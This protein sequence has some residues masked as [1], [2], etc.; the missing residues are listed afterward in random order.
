MG[1]GMIDGSLWQPPNRDSGY[2]TMQAVDN[3][4][5]FCEFLVL[6]LISGLQQLERIQMSRIFPLFF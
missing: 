2:L 3:C 6:K 4:E 1:L 5:A